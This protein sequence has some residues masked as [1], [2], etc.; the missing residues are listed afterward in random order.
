MSAKNELPYWMWMRRRRKTRIETILFQHFPSS[1]SILFLAPVLVRCV[2]VNYFLGFELNDFLLA[3]GYGI[4]RFHLK[5]RTARIFDSIL[6]IEVAFV[7][8]NAMKSRGSERKT[9]Q[10]VSVA[11]VSDNFSLAVCLVL[12]VVVCCSTAQKMALYLRRVC[13]IVAELTAKIQP[14]S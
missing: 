11:L 2:G 3:F 5:T 9:Q 6:P 13:A 12:I 10:V 7:E 1:F 8:A 4:K 14:M